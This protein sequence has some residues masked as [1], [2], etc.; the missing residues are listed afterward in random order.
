MSPCLLRLCAWRLRAIVLNLPFVVGLASVAQLLALAGCDVRGEMPG[1]ETPSRHVADATQTAT[2]AGDAAAVL[3]GSG[4]GPDT[5]AALDANAAPNPREASPGIT[6][7]G[8]S[9][10]DASGH[11]VGEDPAR[12]AGLEA[13]RDAEA[14]D[15]A[16]GSLDASAAEPGPS[17]ILGEPLDAKPGVWTYTEFPDS[18][19]R[20]GSR[21]GIA[22]SKQAG[23]TKLMI[24][25]EG[26]VYCFDG[27]TCLINP[28]N[29][30]DLIFNSARRAP[31]EGIFDRDN[32]ANPVRDWNFV[33]VPYCTGDG[34]GGGKATLSDVQGGP[35]QQRFVGH[36]NLRKFLRRVVPTFPNLSDLLLTGM[37]AGGFGVLQ[38]LALV[39]EA[40]PRLKVRYIDDSGPVPS[41]AV[42]APCL[43][44]LERTL[45]GLDATSLAA[46][47]ASC[48]HP[49]DYLQ[50]NALY[51]ARRFADRPAGFIS[52]I[53]DGAMRMFL[54]V[55][56]RNCTGSLL[57]D[58]VSAEAYA[59]D[60]LAFRERLRAFPA[61]G[62]FLAPGT[63]H[64]WLRSNSFYTQTSQGTKLVDWF[65]KIANDQAA[66][67]I[68]P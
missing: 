21:A 5:A 62:T 1:A 41:K 7:A 59:A 29:V 6:D 42:A 14:P 28:A 11:D 34:H 18:Q 53:E 68:G 64:T 39:Q 25:L 37:S 3:P 47:G 44:T 22:L 35:R 48:P 50:D 8:A 45:W 65:A 38:T 49:D 16:L 20:D 4:S 30:D 55:G 12:E 60:L 9:D 24:Y 19:C 63:Q 23:S 36:D 52:S 40:F 57:F 67:H 43:Q 27:L 32:P 2:A 31:T 66:G 46:C 58:S 56:L 54:G 15:A 13:G 26:G 33:Y 17:W 51:L 61:Y 10:R